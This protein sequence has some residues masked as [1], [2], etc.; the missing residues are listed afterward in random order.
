MC[1]TGEY[2]WP[3]MT[4]VY[5]A[6][7][8]YALFAL[9]AKRKEERVSSL[10]LMH[11]KNWRGDVCK[12][13][14]D[15]HA[16]D[17]KPLCVSRLCWSGFWPSIGCTTCSRRRS[18]WINIARVPF[19]ASAECWAQLEA[20]TNKVVRQLP[21]K[22]CIGPHGLVGYLESE[23]HRVP[24]AWLHVKRNFKSW[25][26]SALR[27]FEIHEA[28]KVTETKR[29]KKNKWQKNKGSQKERATERRKSQKE[30]ATKRRKSQKERATEKRKCARR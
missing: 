23:H 1:G 17:M 28:G 27:R 6:S 4:H 11:C 9:V 2:W 16:F 24:K 30:R 14:I 26:T 13:L 18:K 12:V 19:K 5:W 21:P 10:V 20:A 15:W 7:Q 22:A 3:L 8:A 25:E 29:D